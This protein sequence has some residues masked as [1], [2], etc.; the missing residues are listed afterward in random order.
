MC[1]IHKIGKVLLEYNAGICTILFHDE[2]TWYFFN[3]ILH[4]EE[5]VSTFSI[6]NICKEESAIRREQPGTTECENYLLWSNNH[7]SCGYNDI[8]IACSI[9]QQ[10]QARMIAQVAAP[11]MLC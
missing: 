10:P 3:S 4:Y 6:L 7:L 2:A 11:K 8:L 1:I 5:N 9:L